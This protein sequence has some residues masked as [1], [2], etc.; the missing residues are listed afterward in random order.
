MTVTTPLL[1]RRAVVQA[2]VEATYGVAE[3]LGTDDGVLVME[4]N[5][6][7]DTTVLERDIVTDDLSPLPIIIG[8]KLAKATFSTELRGSGYQNSGLA[9]DAPIIASLFRACG[10][11]LT[12]MPDGEGKGPYEVGVHQ[13]RVSWSV[14]DAAITNDD[15]VAYYL[16]VTTGGASGTAEI[17]VTS[18]TTGEESAAA[19]VTSGTAI[20]LGTLGLEITPTWTGNLNAGDRWIVWLLPS[21]MRLD[22]VSDN[23]ESCT[24]GLNKDGVYHEL[25][26]CFGTFDIEAEAGQYARIN[27]EFTG[28]FVDPVDDALAS[29]DYETSLPSQVELARLQADDT[30]IIVAKFTYDQANDI[31]IRPDVSSK[32]GYIGTRIVGRTP[33]GGIDPEAEKVADYDF[34]GR[35]AKATRMPF[36]MRVGTERGN[37]VWIMAPCVQYSGLTYTDRDGILTYDAGLRFARYNGNDEISFVLV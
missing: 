20:A 12:L 16:E 31:Q 25:P 7:V 37:T 4:P 30:R 1:T 2:K 33:E 35:L 28:I 24:I 19:A 26:G 15:V 36:Q 11:S 32:E 17:T 34:W 27:W 8:R 5:Y 10:Y 18:D 6:E 21:G 13:N 3:T 9:T 23:F 14:D 22:P 29:P